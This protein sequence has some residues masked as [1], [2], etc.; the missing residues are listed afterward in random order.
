M[1][2]DVLHFTSGS[3]KG[4][5]PI[6][7]DIEKML[8]SDSEVSVYA[9]SINFAWRLCRQPYQDGIFDV[10]SKETQVIP[11]WT[12]FNT[13]LQDN[14][15]LRECTIGYCEVI[16]ASP[17]ELPTVYTLL[18]RSLKMADQLGQEDV[19]VVFD[20]A[21]YA[22]VLEIIWQN[23]EEF[24]RLVVRMGTFHTICAFLAAI[25]KRFGDGGLSDILLESEVVGSGSIA[26]FLEGR[27]Y[28]R[29]V[30]IHKVIGLHK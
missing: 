25:G 21:I 18:Q 19:I 14:H 3:R 15:H 8:N 10:K 13:I 16:D 29:A 24:K 9:Q 2:S 12:G 30:R 4:P 27:H 20:Q 28:N 6:I 17:T 26:A 1:P 23:Q 22:K 7:I 5:N 11:V